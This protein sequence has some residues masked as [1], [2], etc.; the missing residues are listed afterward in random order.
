MRAIVLLLLPLSVLAADQAKKPAQPKTKAAVKRTAPSAPAIPPEAVEIAPQ[1][2]RYTDKD[3]KNWIYH[4][5]PFGASKEEEKVGEAK[6]APVVDTTPVK[7]SVEGEEVRFERKMP[8]GKQTWTKKKSE[9]NDEERTWLAEQQ[10]DADSSANRT[11]T[12]EK[13]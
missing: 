6:P 7:V 3:G 10:K 12:T 1:T 8:F 4:R 13:R 2:Y 9:L 11:K 5:T